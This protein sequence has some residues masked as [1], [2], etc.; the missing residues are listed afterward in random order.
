MPTTEQKLQAARALLAAL[1]GLGMDYHDGSQCF[2]FCAEYG[3]TD[4]SPACEAARAAIAQAEAA[5]I[6]S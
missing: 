4:H 2:G 3:C 5:G 6:R 1:Q